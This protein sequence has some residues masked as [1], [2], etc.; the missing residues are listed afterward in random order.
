MLTVVTCFSLG[1][2]LQPF[3]AAGFFYELHRMRGRGGG[4]TH[5]FIHGCIVKEEQCKETT[6]NNLLMNV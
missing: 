2:S 5:G 4:V 1:W 3:M 6:G